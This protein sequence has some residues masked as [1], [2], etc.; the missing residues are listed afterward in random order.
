MQGK[1]V[2]LPKKCKTTSKNVKLPQKDVKP[3]QKM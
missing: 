1:N 3:P 2:K